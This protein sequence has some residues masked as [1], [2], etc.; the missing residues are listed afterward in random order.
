[1]P[2]LKFTV[3]SNLFRELGER[4]VGK[5]SI[6][7][8]ELVKNSYDADATEVKIELSPED[9]YLA[10][11]DNGHGMNLEEFED[12]WMRV[13]SPHK[14]EK[15]TSKNF[16]RRMTGQKGV[17]RLSAQMLAGH[18]EL[19]TVSDLDPTKKISAEVHWSEAIGAGDLTEATVEYEIENSEEGFESGTDIILSDLKEDWDKEMVEG[20]AGELWWLVPPFKGEKGAE[21]KNRFNI[22]FISPVEEYEETF[23]KQMKAIL[24]I[25]HAKIVGENDNGKVKFSLEFKSE[26][27]PIKDSFEIEDL[28]DLEEVDFDECKL[29]NGRFQIRIYH[30]RHRQP[31]GIKVGKARE[32]FNEYGGVNIY[33]GG[34]RLP[35]YGTPDN[36][37]LDLEK[38]HALRRTRSDLLPDDIQVGQGLQYL[39]NLTRVF[40]VVKINTTEEDELD[41]LVTRDRL[42]EGE[43]FENLRYMIKYVM[44]QYA[45]EEARRR[46]KE[47]EK[48]RDTEKV[49]EEFE[50]VE[51]A[52]SK[53]EE[54]IPEDAFQDIEKG[55][56]NYSQSVNEEL[57]REREKTS[58]LSSLATAGISALS[59]RHEITLQYDQLEAIKED[60]EEI[61]TENEEDRKKLKKAIGELDS[62]VE[63]AQN[64]NALFKHVAEEEYREDKDRYKVRFVVDEVLRQLGDFIGDVSTETES[65]D[66]ELRLP[67][68]S[69]AEWSSVFQN[70]LTNAY[71]AVIDPEVDTEKEIIDISTRG[72]DEIKKVLIQNTGRS[73]DLSK[74]EEYFEPF[75]RETN[76]ES[77]RRALGYG[78]TGL[79]LTIVD[80]ISNK[81][82][83]DVSFVEP[84]EDFSTA[85]SISWKEG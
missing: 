17:G 2:E 1:M 39:P 61:R 70:L 43:A 80:M 69:V 30:L 54:S 81:I 72:K 29:E 79:G 9:D 34:F 58:L 64:K 44:H 16:G 21:L 14:E 36:D 42:Q 57:E 25:W 5:P 28:A 55:I 67:E 49:E 56:E 63:T 51:K 53:H 35:Y 32:Y 24:D 85:L 19:E 52:L 74:S 13:G 48:E 40:G 47:K 23:E 18:L 38:I 83:C 33:D 71:N 27:E 26:D 6:A 73:V 59:L 65:I 4:L 22:N 75:V 20:L 41:I 8:A 77:N 46:L 84:E 62:W 37:W 76:V 45:M 66:N 68:A 10:V 11:K 60:L 12:F 82:G 15:E 3:D 50:S 7:L 78:G 31:H